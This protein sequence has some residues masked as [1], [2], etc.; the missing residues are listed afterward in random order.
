MYKDATIKM[1]VQCSDASMFSLKFYAKVN[2]TMISSYKNIVKFLPVHHSFL[3]CLTVNRHLLI[4]L[5]N[6][7]DQHRAKRHEPRSVKT[8]LND[9][10]DFLC[11]KH[12]KNTKK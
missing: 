9:I 1:A 10:Y 8:G 7:M 3:F 6:N 12:L 11:K 5:N 2:L 4:T